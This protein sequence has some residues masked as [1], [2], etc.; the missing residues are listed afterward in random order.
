MILRLMYIIVWLLIGLPVCLYACYKQREDL[1]KWAYYFDNDEDGFDGA[2]GHFYGK[3]LGKD[4][5]S[6]CWLERGWTAYKW[7]AVRNPC[8]NLRKHPKVGVDIRSPEDITF[9]GNTYHHQSK[10]SFEPN[11]RD[12]KWYK[13]VSIFNGEEYTSRFY[14][15]PLFKGYL[16]IRMG[17]KIYPSYYFDEYWLGKIEKEGWPEHKEYGLKVFS[18]KWRKWDK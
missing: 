6:M 1:W 10:W 18:I 17:L 14:M 5:K 3:Y 16:Y 13:V 2:K 15:V 7:S 9:E 11:K 4:I 8:Y 12:K